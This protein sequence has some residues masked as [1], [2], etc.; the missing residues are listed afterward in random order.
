MT[1][2]TLKLII[3]GSLFLHAIAHALAL[4]AFLAEGLGLRK[5]EA[6]RPRSGL[7]LRLTPRAATVV[8]S[9]IWAASA[10]GFLAAAA[11]FWGILAIGTTWRTIAIASSCVS[12]L[13]IIVRGGAWP[14]SGSVSRSTLNTLVAMTMNIA[15]LVALVWLRWPPP[16]MFGR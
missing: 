3:A 13:G 10:M 5:V 4:L 7:L 14:G 15:V 16:G 6:V 2:D 9:V 1:S 11:G 8:E 12:T